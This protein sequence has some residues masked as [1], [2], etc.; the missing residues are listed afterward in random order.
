MN[1]QELTTILEDRGLE[2]YKYGGRCMYGAQCPAVTIDRET[3][4]LGVVANI[5]TDFAYANN[6][7]EDDELYDL[8]EVFDGAVTDNM[9]LDTVLYFPNVRY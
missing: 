3:N 8:A 5:V 2:V 9:G 4:I 1:A 6:N 7:L